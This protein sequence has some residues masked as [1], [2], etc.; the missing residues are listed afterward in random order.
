[1]SSLPWLAVAA[2]ALVS[3]LVAKLALFALVA[4]VIAWAALPD[5]SKP[6]ARA[7]RVLVAVAGLIALVASARFV[8][9]EGMPGIV[10]GG[11]RATEFRAVS[12]LR[13][14]LFAQDLLRRNG[15][16]DPDGDG[17]GSA[18]RLAELTAE[19]GVRGERRLSPP[20]LENYPKTIDTPIGPAAEL[21]GYLFTICLPSANG[22]FSAREDEPVDE[23]LAERRFLAYAWPISKG[24]GSAAYFLDEHERILWAPASFEPGA[25]KRSGYANPPPCDDALAP[26]SRG[27]W[28]TWRDKKPRSKLPGDEPRPKG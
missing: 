9:T 22:G 27:D 5:R 28:Q 10:E 2:F 18:A 25:E 4:A 24:S 1:M 17:I 20:L 13:E 12:R 14:I 21:S 15:L 19:R 26:A 8:I 23:E 7:A 11:T 6:G 16:H 3:L